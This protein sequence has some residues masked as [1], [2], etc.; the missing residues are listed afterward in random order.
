MLR[1][2]EYVNTV[3]N[4]TNN[5]WDDGATNDDS[6]AKQSA[7]SLWDDVKN[8]VGRIWEQDVYGGIIKPFAE[9][10]EQAFGQIAAANNQQANAITQ[11][12][13]DLGG[14]SDTRA[15]DMQQIEDA[16]DYRNSAG[17]EVLNGPAML[18]PQ[19]AA[20][21]FIGDAINT[22]IDKGSVGAGV[23]AATYGPLSDFAS[24]ENLGDRFIE[25]P[26]T[27]TNPSC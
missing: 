15:Q 10:A 24:Q 12:I 13:E 3:Q 14:D 22:A 1:V 2:N 23:R 21:V 27:T 16:S 19:I 18:V 26:I 20:P 6:G 9:G 4:D 5:G 8:I 25:Q 11:S 7:P 17:Q